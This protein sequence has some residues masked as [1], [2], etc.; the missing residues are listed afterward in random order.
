[1]KEIKKK[2]LDNGDDIIDKNKFV[3]EMK[4][5]YC[6]LLVDETTISLI[7][8]YDFI[9]FVEWNKKTQLMNKTQYKRSDNDATEKKFERDKKFITML[10]KNIECLTKGFRNLENRLS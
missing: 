1:M 5:F 9:T 4:L 10:S 3:L 8:G 7:Q 6:S 2:Y